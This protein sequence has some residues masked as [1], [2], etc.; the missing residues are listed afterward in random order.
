MRKVT[1]VGV[2]VLVSVFGIMVYWGN[3]YGFGNPFNPYGAALGQLNMAETAQTPQEVIHHL[4]IA[5][6]LLPENGAVSSWSNGQNDFETIQNKLDD[7]VSRAT[8]ISSLDLSS[9]IYVT[10]MTDIHLQL[11]EIQETLLAF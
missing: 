7:L 6:G 5:K 1:T 2:A 9:E 11:K 3:A 4:A 10:E 8:I